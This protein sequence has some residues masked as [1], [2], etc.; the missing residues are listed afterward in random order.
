[1][2]FT[3]FH[4]GPHATVGLLAPRLIDLPVFVLAN[5]VIDLEPL[6]VMVFD[7]R[8]PLHGYAHTLL[9]GGLLGL[10]WGLA[11]WPARPLFARV[12]GWLHLPYDPG[13]ARMALSGLLGAW[14]HVLTDTPLYPEMQPFFPLA[15]NPLLGAVG[16]RTMYRACALLLVPALTLYLFRVWQAGHRSPTTPPPTTRT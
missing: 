12:M 3:P 11:A 1:M 10:A 4:T 2:P 5:V 13:P 16:H 14:L 6:A 8:Y 15:G 7:L 9:V